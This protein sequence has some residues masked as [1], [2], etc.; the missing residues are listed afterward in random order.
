M[1]TQV[2]AKFFKPYF[3][4]RKRTIVDLYDI[5]GIRDEPILDM[6][7]YERDMAAVKAQVDAQKNS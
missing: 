1:R 2:N 3:G 5:K 4:F 7:S 6:E